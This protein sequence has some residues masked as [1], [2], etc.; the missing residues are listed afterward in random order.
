MTPWLIGSGAKMV[1]WNIWVHWILPVEL[2]YISFRECLAL[3]LRWSSANGWIIEGIQTLLITYRSQFWALACCGSAGQDSMLA[4]PTQRGTFTWKK[5]TKTTL[6]VNLLFVFSG[7]ASLALINTH[8]AAAAGLITW[9]LI[10][11][12][13]GH[14]SVSGSCIG[15]IVGLVCVTP[16]CGFIDPGWSILFGV[17]PVIIIYFL[18]VYKH[19][20]RVDDTLD[21][22]LVHGV[23]KFHWHIKTETTLLFRRSHRCLHDWLIR[24]SRC[25]SSRRQWC[26]LWPSHSDVVSNSWHSHSH[27]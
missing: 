12:I 11:A 27:W 4:Q 24:G 8:A 20:L 18:L 15:P 5:L 7:L 1:G 23:G 3:L 22:A 9:T 19:H 25:Q 17:I 6:D 10:D 14:V 26:V 16:A 21:V 13:R 2:W